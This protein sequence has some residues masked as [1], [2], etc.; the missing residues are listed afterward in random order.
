MTQLPSDLLPCLIETSPHA[1]VI[2]DQDRFVK[3]WNPVAEAAFEIPA[4]EAIGSVIDDLLGLD[5][6]VSANSRVLRLA[7]TQTARKSG[8]AIQIEQFVHRIPVEDQQWTIAYI[9]DVTVSRAHERR[10]ANEALTDPLSGLANRRG[11]QNQLETALKGKLTLAIIDADNFKQIN[12]RFGHEAGD[13]AIQHLATQLVEC[14]PDAVCCS[15][16]GGDEFGV[17]LKTGA[18]PETQAEFEILRQ[19]ITSRQPQQHSFSLT[20]SIGVALSNVPG[21]AARELLTTADRCMYRAK[22]AG[23]NQIVI[24]PINV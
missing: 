20:V 13:T 16:L 23:R 9:N 7:E 4:T 3:C 2:I 10:L 8:R 5:S 17:V 19:R 22:A 18:M 21:T 15:R 11:F 1:V 6:A 24:Q 12:D 14:F